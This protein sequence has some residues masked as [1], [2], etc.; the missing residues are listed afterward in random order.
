MITKDKVSDSLSKDVAE[1]S[2]SVGPLI[3][4]KTSE[5]RKDVSIKNDSLDNQTSFTD[6]TNK[7]N[8]NNQ[9]IKNLTFS[10]TFQKK[11]SPQKSIEF[12]FNWNLVIHSK[13]LNW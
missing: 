13:N 12:Y 9:V 7:L 3:R 11:I 5:S 4:N 10:P 2:D 8:S 1:V 6:S